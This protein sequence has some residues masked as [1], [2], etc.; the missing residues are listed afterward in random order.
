MDADTERPPFQK[1]KYIYIAPPL[2]LSFDIKQTQIKA[3]DI[4]YVNLF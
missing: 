1:K 3:V 4:D 2:T